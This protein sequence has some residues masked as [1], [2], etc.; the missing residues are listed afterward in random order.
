MDEAAGGYLYDLSRWDQC[1]IKNNSNLNTAIQW[2]NRCTF[3]TIWYFRVTD[4]QG[5]YTITAIPYSGS[6]ESFR[7]TRLCMGCISL[8]QTNKVFI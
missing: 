8:T 6:G 2:D 7:I 1:I 5:Y 3:C 4:A